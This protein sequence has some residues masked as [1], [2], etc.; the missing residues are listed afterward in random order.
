MLQMEWALLADGVPAD[1]LYP[2]DTDRAFSK[3]DEIRPH[4]RWWDSGAESVQLVAQGESAIGTSFASRVQNAAKDGVPLELVWNQGG[5]GNT[6]LVVPKGA[7]NRDNAMRL[8]NSIIQAEAQ[9]RMS[10]LNEQAPANPSALDLIDPGLARQLATYPE[11]ARHMFYVDEQGYWA[12]NYEQVKRRFDL[13][14]RS[15]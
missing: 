11:N 15:R 13:W 14:L 5:I 6:Y 8:I 3:L 4:V 9:A 12:E 10:T 7:T 2:L 1:E